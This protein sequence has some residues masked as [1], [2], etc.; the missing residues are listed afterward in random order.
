MLVRIERRHKYG[1]SNMS[2]LSSQKFPETLCSSI[3]NKLHLTNPKLKDS[4]Y[5]EKSSLATKVHEFDAFSYDLKNLHSHN[6]D[7]MRIAY[8]A[9]KE[10]RNGSENR[11]KTL[12]PARKLRRDSTCTKEFLNKNAEIETQQVSQPAFRQKTAENDFK[13]N[14][15][16]DFRN[17]LKRRYFFSKDIGKIFGAWNRSEKGKISGK[18][19]EEMSE[20]LGIPLNKKESQILL[21]IFAK[22]DSD[23][24]RCKNFCDIIFKEDFFNYLVS[25]GEFENIKD[26]SEIKN[27]IKIRENE[28]GKE[29]RIFDLKKGLEKDFKGVWKNRPVAETFTKE[30]FVNEFLQNQAADHLKFDNMQNKLEAL[31]GLFEKLKNDQGTVNI[32]D[33]C[34]PLSEAQKRRLS[35]QPNF[36]PHS[37]AKINKFDFF[38]TKNKREIPINQLENDFKCINRVK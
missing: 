20:G 17:T 21:S 29:K 14:K 24:L 37:N 16:I 32:R 6:N 34:E 38:L 10:N 22:G 4:S 33:L 18:D 23:H 28:F 35:V 5:T 13:I 27:L 12:L 36:V 2:S 31:D 9:E 8:L 7:A 26:E 1:N 30:E 11:S 19:I 25:K 3:K 15:V